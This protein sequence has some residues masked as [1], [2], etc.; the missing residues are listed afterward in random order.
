MM[1][2]RDSCGSFRKTVDMAMRGVILNVAHASL[3]LTKNQ[4]RRHAISAECEKFRD[5]HR[6]TTLESV[7]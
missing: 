2:P 6:E 7:Q 3:K 1:I 5:M 4:K